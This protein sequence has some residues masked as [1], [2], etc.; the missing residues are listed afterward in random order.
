MSGCD[1]T[2]APT[3]AREEFARAYSCPEDRVVIKPRPDVRW[4]TVLF[5]QLGK[6]APPPEVAADPERLAKWK[7]DQSDADARTAESFDSYDV[8]EGSG[9][10]H[11]VLL[12]CKRPAK[13]N[14]VN[15]ILC[16]IEPLPKGQ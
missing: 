5:P 10:D 12:G 3:R 4:S 1:L 11:D 6:S 8:F 15:R 9:C 16:Q 13:S 2:P 14:G 7:K